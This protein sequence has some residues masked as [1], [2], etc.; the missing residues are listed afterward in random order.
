M[1]R[2]T[3]IRNA[4]ALCLAATVLTAGFTA[5]AVQLTED[6]A[7]RAVIVHNGHTELAPQIPKDARAVKY[8]HIEPAVEALRDYLEKITGAKLPVVATVEDAGD[9]PA[10]VL[11]LVDKVPGA[12]D[13]WVTARQAYRITTEENRIVLTAAEGLGL[14]NAV[15]GF[16]EDHLG[17]HFYSV[18]VSR[19]SHG[20]SRYEGPGF[21]TIPDQPS[22]SVGEIDDLQ[23]PAVPNRGLI[24]KMGNYPWILKNRA[25]SPRGGRTSSAMGCGHT[26]Y[27]W[28]N[29][30]DKKVWVRTEEGRKRVTKKGLMGSHPEFFPMNKQ[31]ERAPD[32]HN[33]GICGTAEGLP[34]YLAGR[35]L[36]R[37]TGKPKD[38]AGMFKI[39]QGDGFQGC[40][41]PDCRKLVHDKQS[42]AAPLIH[43]FNETLDIVTKDYPNVEIMT[44]CYFNSLEAPEDMKVH[45]NLWINVV[46]S[47]RSKNAAGDQM[48]PIQ[49]IPA[50]DDYA[51]ALKEW[52]QLAPDRITVWHWDTYR[53]EWPSMFYIDDNVRYMAD[54]GVYA[55]NPQTCGGPWTDMINWLYMKL[56]WNP[57][58]DGDALIRQYLEDV[59][60]KAAAPYLYD[61]LQTGKDAYEA[62]LHY[63][64][65]VRW[66]GWTRITMDKLFPESVRA[67]MVP[68]M[69][70]A[71]A[72]CRKH[73]TD[74][75]FAE[76][77]K[78]RAASIDKVVLEAARQIGNWG[79][80]KY[81]G[82]TWYVPS[83]DPNVPPIL[84]RATEGMAGDMFGYS[85]Y[86]WDKGGAA[87]EVSKRRMSAAVVPELKGRIVSAAVK[88]TE[89][90][91]TGSEAGGYEDEFHRRVWGRV[92]M[93]ANLDGDLKKVNWANLWRDFEPAQS[94]TLATRTMLRR[95]GFKTS[96]ELHRT[97]TVSNDGMRIER[98]YSGD[99]GIGEPFAA[100]WRLA[101]PHPDKS[102]LTVSGGG[103]KELMDLRYAEPGGIRTVKAGERPPGY[104]GL[105]AMDEK[106][107]AVKAVSDAQAVEFEIGKPDG[108]LEIL[109]DRGDGMAAVV[110]TPAAGWSKISIQPAVGENYVE[111]T[112][113]G[114]PAKAEGDAVDD[115]PLPAQTL[116]TRDMP[117]GESV[118][119]AS[120]TSDRPDRRSQI[121]I[122]GENTAVN[123]ID[124]AELIRVPAGTFRRGSDSDIAGADEQPVRDIHLDEYWVYKYPVTVGQCKKFCEAMGK[125]FKAPWPQNTKAQPEGDED[126]Y[127]AITNWYD[128]REYA[129]WA[130]GNLPTEAQWEKAAR[131]TDGREY[132]WGNEYDPSKCVS[133]ENTL[134]EFNEGFRPVGSH[135]DGASPYGVMD[136]AGNVWEWT[137]DWY[138]YEYYAESPDKNPTGPEVGANKVVRGGC[139]LYDWR[140]NRSAARF[141]QPPAVNN[142][143]GVGFR[144]VISA[145]GSA[146]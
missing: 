8:G 35:V 143:T 75:Q 20:V 114:K 90:L 128:A 116:S 112:L 123:E 105:D 7:P 70:K 109:L 43:M 50:N 61:Y 72:A 59:Y 129:R 47:A 52:P 44:F 15:F 104:E 121:R 93:P 76:L 138:R 89:L 132:P 124:G 113:V 99:P 26:M 30:N 79:M 136:M 5:S 24:F 142:W 9:L 34:A 92:W 62:A 48:G 108:D 115:L 126:S 94:D 110:T 4:L 29:P 140:F 103:I 11:R 101:M 83:A 78:A 117:P 16:L 100:R 32:M 14:H 21:E 57:E 119:D 131:G 64:S 66:S 55:I 49:G 65:A 69:D 25:V 127:A 38:T 17:C 73:G 28:I 33:Q 74:E 18:H 71:W 120:D 87:V 3:V 141:V 107:D 77:K 56:S 2:S 133:M 111:L 122:T 13:R 22:L 91:H 81:D 19:H 31:G 67:K 1:N 125:E 46:S 45:D 85:R 37:L 95:G 68:L 63:P 144:V 39:G 82:T 134:Y 51:R 135:P 139:A 40:H 145:P 146:K 23:E 54:C 60:S 41:C 27:S 97:V 36:E 58:R 42:E 80:T 12:S 98:S 130:R 88:K 96:G 10:I 84:E 118:A 86:I 102:R 6:G 53:P 106:W 137:R